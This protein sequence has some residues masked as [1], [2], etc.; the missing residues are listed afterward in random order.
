MSNF[1][2]KTL[3]IFECQSKVKAKILK[4][5][6]ANWEHGVGMGFP[7]VQGYGLFTFDSMP[8][9]IHWFQRGK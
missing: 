9:V 5:G 6:V 3:S 1:L 2:Q 7:N 4:S 8:H